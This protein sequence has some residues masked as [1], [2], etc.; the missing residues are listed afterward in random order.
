MTYEVVGWSGSVV[1]GGAG[2]KPALLRDP[3]T[4][5]YANAADA[6]EARSW[7]DEDEIAGFAKRN[8]LTRR[9]L[10][11]RAVPDGVVL[12]AANEFIGRGKQDRLILDPTPLALHSL[13][14]ELFVW[15]GYMPLAEATK[16]MQTWGARLLADADTQLRERTRDPD[17]RLAAARALDDAIRA[18]YC[19]SPPEH[20]LRYDV[21]RVMA[22]ASRVLEQRLDPIYLDAAIDLSP[23]RLEHLRRDVEAFTPQGNAAFTQEDTPTD[24]HPPPFGRRGRHARTSIRDQGSQPQA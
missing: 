5:R 22:T 13:S 8:L 4:G 14:P 16:L 1:P 17:C 20:Q 18:R 21:F 11:A 15:V 6:P 12:Y 10:H 9:D 2:I 19:I 24:L 7:H 23:D 3:A